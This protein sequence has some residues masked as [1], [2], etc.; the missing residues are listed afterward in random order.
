MVSTFLFWQLG[1]EFQQQCYQKDVPLPTVFV[2]NKEKM[3]ASKRVKGHSRVSFF[4]K[5]DWLCDKIGGQ[6]MA[7]KSKKEKAAG[8]EQ[9]RQLK[10]AKKMQMKQKKKVALPQKHRKNKR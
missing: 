1:K 4:N 10:R 9:H 7:K 8:L 2:C 3:R 5:Y 6:N